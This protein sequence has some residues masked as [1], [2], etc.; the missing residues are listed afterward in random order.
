MILLSS[1]SWKDTF[2]DRLLNLPSGH[3]ASER[4]RV[5]V[6]PS[7]YDILVGR[8]SS[9]RLHDVPLVEVL[10]NPREELAF[11]VKSIS[12]RLIAGVLLV[13]SSPLV[14]VAAG[15]VKLSSSG[16]VLYRNGG[17][18]GTAKHSPCINCA[19]WSTRLRLTPVRCWPA[20]MT[21]G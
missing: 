14:G 21:A 19:P 20:R 12:D 16:P 9:V 8:V 6:V 11:V 7:V 10:K 4:P 3:M 5:L 2:V 13:L 17:W 18:A 15:L 1:A